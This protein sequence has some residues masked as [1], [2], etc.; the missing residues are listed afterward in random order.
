MQQVLI[1]SACRPLHHIFFACCKSCFTSGSRAGLGHAGPAFGRDTPAY[2]S[3]SSPLALT[4]AS[5]IR[6]AS[7]LS[8]FDR[9]PPLAC[10][11]AA[12]VGKVEMETKADAKA[13]KDSPAVLTVATG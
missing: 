11:A 12:L 4:P 5:K 9:A 6:M 1:R 10:V 2:V 8:F 3:F 7:Q 13:T